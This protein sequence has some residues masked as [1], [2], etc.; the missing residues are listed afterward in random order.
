MCSVDFTL[1]MSLSKKTRRHL[2]A[3][4]DFGVLSG[5]MRC[6]K[7]PSLVGD[8]CTFTWHGTESGE[9]QMLYDKAQRGTITFQ[10]NG[11][12][13]GFIE[14]GFFGKAQFVGTRNAEASFNRVWCMYVKQWKATYRSINESAYGVA[15]ASRWG[16]WVEDTSRPDRPED[17]DTSG[18]SAKSSRSSY[19]S[20]DEDGQESNSDPRGGELETF[21]SRNWP[22]QT[23]HKT[24]SYLQ[25]QPQDSDDERPP[26]RRTKQTARRGG[27]SGSRIAELTTSTRR[28]KEK[29]VEVCF[30]IFNHQEEH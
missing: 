16:G 11:R 17:S 20:D 12:F 30:P 28:E 3:Y 19:C 9:G 15:E 29:L 5:V 13:K 2:W 25:A 4:F 1:R 8:S 14:G 26:K 7:P 21:Q 10:G 22:R 27:Y 18:G 6:S 24:S 23:A